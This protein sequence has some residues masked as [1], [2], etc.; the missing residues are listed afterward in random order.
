MS[1]SDLIWNQM[2]DA[3]AFRGLDGSGF[4]KDDYAGLSHTRLSIIDLSSGNQPMHDHSGRYVITFNGEIYNYLELKSQYQEKGAKFLTKSDTEVILEGFKLKQENVLQDLNGMF[5]FTI[6]DRK[7]KRLFIARDRL[8]KKPLFWTKIKG[9]YYFS[10][11][12]NSL[13]KIFKT[14]ININ[15]LEQVEI[16]GSSIDQSTIWKNIFSFPFASYAYLDADK[17]IHPQKYWNISFS[18]KSHSRKSDLIEE[19]EEI[20]TDSI[21]IRLRSDVPLCLTFSGGVDSGTIACIVSKKLNKNVRLFCIDYDSPEDQSPETEQAQKVASILGLELNHINYDYLR[22]MLSDFDESYKNFDMPCMQFALVYSNILYKNIQEY[23]KVTLT[24]NGADELFTGYIG[25]EKSYFKNFIHQNFSK[26]H[27]FIPILKNHSLFKNGL[28]N[29]YIKSNTKLLDDND[30]ICGN[31]QNELRSANV[32]NYYDLQM[33]MSLFYGARDANFTLPDLTGLSRQ[34]EVRSPYLDYRMVEFA[35]RL[36]LKF[37]IHISKTGKLITKYLPK[38]YYEKYVTKDLSFAPKKGM[39]YNIFWPHAIATDDNFKNIFKTRLNEL[40]ATKIL[41][42]IS[43]K[44]EFD[45]YCA[46]VMKGH[47]Y[48]SN[49]TKLMFGFMLSSWLNNQKILNP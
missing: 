49:G 6:W 3:I 17:D 48:G 18:E 37:K 27:K 34:I 12:A 2:K 9:I 35:A 41:K 33:Y 47:R 28:I 16:F 23:A 31:L 1:I 26:V 13:T 29:H 7:E 46:E 22:N 30:H 25:D 14:D 32:S 24:G 15:Y 5:V 10:S 42:N 11:S 40:D 38:C 20:L 8:G 4:W 44:S 21:R 36:P 19:Y 39:G 45:K 43:F